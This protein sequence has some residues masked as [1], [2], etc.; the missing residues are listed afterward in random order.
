M[1]ITK[2]MKKNLQTSATNLID[3][4]VDL[5][6]SLLEAPQ[7][8]DLPAVTGRSIAALLNSKEFKSPVSDAEIVDCFAKAD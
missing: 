6:E 1:K 4:E 5:D 7:N 3:D 2:R 8:S